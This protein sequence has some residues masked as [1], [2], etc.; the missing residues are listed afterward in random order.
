MERSYFL[1]P[2]RSGIGLGMA[3][4]RDPGG[5]AGTVLLTRGPTKTPLGLFLNIVHSCTCAERRASHQLQTYE[6]RDLT[7]V[8]HHDSRKG[9]FRDYACSWTSH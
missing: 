2:A 3:G 9:V 7:D 6:H 1:Y 5:S 8:Q 4:Y